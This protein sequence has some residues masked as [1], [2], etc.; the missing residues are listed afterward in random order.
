MRAKSYRVS[1]HLVSNWS[2]GPFFS[3][4]ADLCTNILQIV[5]WPFFFFLT[6]IHNNIRALCRTWCTSVNFHVLF[7]QNVSWKWCE[8]RQM[9]LAD[10]QQTVTSVTHA[11]VACTLV[12]K[13]SYSP[14]FMY[15]HTQ[16]NFFLKNRYS[17]FGLFSFNQTS[18]IN[19]Q[20][21]CFTPFLF[22]SPQ[23]HYGPALTEAFIKCQLYT[24]D[25][26]VVGED[27]MISDPKRSDCLWAF[28][29][30]WRD[31]LSTL[32]SSTLSLQLWEGEKHDIAGPISFFLITIE[33]SLPM[34][35]KC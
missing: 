23:Y 28:S 26:T 14:F 3:N 4:F 18:S 27:T 12:F 19:P 6:H 30:C 32:S 17:F 34:F 35:N 20:C 22:S 31:S 13:N 15:C 29:F 2:R 10:R 11:G 16:A 21:P 7:H 25:H 8:S 24:R 1:P 9:E 33:Q 5:W